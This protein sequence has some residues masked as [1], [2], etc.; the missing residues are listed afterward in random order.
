MSIVKCSDSLLSTFFNE[1]ALLPLLF[2]HK[3]GIFMSDVVLGSDGRSKFGVCVETDLCCSD[4][5]VREMHGMVG[6]FDAVV[7]GVV[8]Q[9][10]GAEATGILGIS[11]F[12]PHSAEL[13]VPKGVGI[14]VR[15]VVEPA[16]FFVKSQVLCNLGYV[17][18]ETDGVVVVTKTVDRG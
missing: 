7:L 13:G 11:S 9:D 3:V 14:V 8:G 18:G 4:V 10:E 1:L 5:E 16:N 12:I 17:D 6:R 15:V 2:G